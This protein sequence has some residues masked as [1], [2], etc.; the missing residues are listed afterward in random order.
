MARGELDALGG[1]QIEKRV[2]PRRRHPVDRIDHGFV[3]LRPGDGEHVRVAGGDLFGL[4]TH[5]A[6]DDHLAVLVERR[7]DGGKGFLLRAVEKAAGI[8]DRE[9]GAGMPPGELI[10]FCAQPRDDALGIDQRLGAAEGDEAH[11]RGTGL[12]HNR[13]RLGCA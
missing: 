9:V 2:V 3:L 11:P 6:G 8:D 13:S 7:A 1:H 12:G 5:A 4:G 10:A